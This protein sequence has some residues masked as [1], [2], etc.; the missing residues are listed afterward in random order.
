MA[1][2]AWKC[3]HGYIIVLPTAAPQAYEGSTQQIN[4]FECK[5]DFEMELHRAFSVTGAM[6]ITKN[7]VSNTK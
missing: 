2:R 3:R 5:V 4:S 7:V 6:Y 1:L